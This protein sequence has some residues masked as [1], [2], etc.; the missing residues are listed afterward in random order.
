[1]CRSSIF[2]AVNIISRNRF[3]VGLYDRNMHDRFDKSFS[4][5]A[6]PNNREK[7]GCL[8]VDDVVT[9]GL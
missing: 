6:K 8:S 4:S 9:N 1:M 2:K 3:T 7:T 5:K